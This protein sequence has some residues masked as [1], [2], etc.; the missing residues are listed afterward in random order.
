MVR[1]E[2]NVLTPLLLEDEID[3]TV[4]FH[5][6]AVFDLSR[7]FS[8]GTL[9]LIQGMASIYGCSSLVKGWINPDAEF[10]ATTG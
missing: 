1:R 9:G 3:L 10:N 4:C 2:Q 7:T 8:K 5:K 6:K